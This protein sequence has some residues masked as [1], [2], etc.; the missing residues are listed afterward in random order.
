M[1]TEFLSARLAAVAAVFL[2]LATTVACNQ[3]DDPDEGE[4]V[5]RVTA[6]AFTGVSLAAAAEDVAVKLSL[7]I[8]DRSGL[9]GSF[10]NDVIFT[11]Y[12]VNFSIVAPPTSGV[13]LISTVACPMGGT[14]ELSLVLITAAEK[15]GSGFAAGDTFFATLI[16]SGQDLRGR[17][18]TFDA[19]VVV[20]LT[21]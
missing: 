19:L 1:R 4:A 6:Q 5:I 2:L 17:P 8:E 15:T 16:V 21:A 9:S 18:V 12:E 14:C 13:G 11:D 10:F 20:T 3:H 7:S